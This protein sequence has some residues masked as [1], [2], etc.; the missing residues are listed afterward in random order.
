MDLFETLHVFCPGLTMW[1]TFGCVLRLFLSLFSQFGLL[2]TGYLVD[3]TPFTVLTE[4]FWK[5]SGVLLR[6]EDV[7]DVWL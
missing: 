2:D 6:S 5:V 3:A 1:M 7:F 4:S